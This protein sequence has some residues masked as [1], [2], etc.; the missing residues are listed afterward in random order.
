MNVLYSNTVTLYVVYVAGKDEME[1]HAI[2]TDENKAKR[3]ADMLRYSG[4]VGS[5]YVYKEI[6]EKIYSA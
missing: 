3:C 5:I 1:R 2:Y 6:T 4:F